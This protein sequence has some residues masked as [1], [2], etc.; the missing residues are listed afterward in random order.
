MPK[1]KDFATSYL[2]IVITI[3]TN[4]VLLPIY[5]KYFGSDNYGAWI[6]INTFVQYLALAN[7]G[8]P[9][10][11]TVIG[12]NL[13]NKNLIN[14]LYK[15]CLKIISIIVI[16]I[17][18][19]GIALVLFEFLVPSMFFGPTKNNAYYFNSLI[20]CFILYC[21]RSPVQLSLSVFSAFGKVYLNKV[22]EI[23]TNLSM[24]LSFGIVYYLKYGIFEYVT[25]AGILML[26]IS[27]CS[28]VHSFIIIE[29]QTK[30]EL[31]VLLDNDEPTNKYILKLS[32]GY[33]LISMS[34]ALVWNTD[35]IIIAHYLPLHDVTIYS[36]TFRIYTLGFI[37]F[38]TINNVLLP[39]YGIYRSQNNF[40]LLEKSFNNAILIS[41][42]FATGLW[43]LTFLFSN[44]IIFFWTKD[45]SLYGGRYLFLILGFYGFVLAILSSF[46]VFFAG[47]KIVKPAIYL[48]FVEGSTNLVF[49]LLLISKFKLIGVALGT[50]IGALTVAVITNIIFKNIAQNLVK[51]PTKILMKNFLL[52]AIFILLILIFNLDANQLILKIF[53]ISVF[54]LC[55][56][57]CF[58]RMNK[59]KITQLKEIL[60][61]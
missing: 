50:L 9:T 28:F 7:F 54:I 33:F 56:T 37:I 55:Y 46:S 24:P 30:S 26:L 57:F 6:L 48:T 22:Y 19:I 45:K 35:N 49:S 10:S 8:I 18:V 58:S 53:I 23:L 1:I 4:F 41:T 17:L 16:V 32:L 47:L 3:I 12:A 5:I 43:M 25:I 52:S 38:N 60:N 40:Q 14:D 2:S 20:I 36:I 51:P 39:Y 13:Q 42:F 61:P 27:I 15:K 59:V 29:T 11:L 34:A 31:K 44:E 21:L